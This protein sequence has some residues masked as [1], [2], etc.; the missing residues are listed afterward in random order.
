MHPCEIEIAACMPRA[1]VENSVISDEPFFALSTAAP[2]PI[3]H[4]HD[5]DPTRAE[6]AVDVP[7]LPVCVRLPLPAVDLLAPGAVLLE[8]DMLLPRGILL[9]AGVLLG[10]QRGRGRGDSE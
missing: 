7:A 4:D 2:A 5:P 9:S 1:R 10:A 6:P 8:G 3:S